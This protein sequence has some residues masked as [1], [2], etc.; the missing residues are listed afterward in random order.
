[1]PKSSSRQADFKRILLI[2]DGRVDLGALTIHR[3]GREIRMTPKAA[4]VLIELAR[5]PGVTLSRDE[6]LE[7]VWSNS[8]TTPDVV[9][10]A[11]TLLRRAFGDT[12]DASRVIETIPKVGYRLIV[13]ARFESPVPAATGPVDEPADEPGTDQLRGPG[14][15]RTESAGAAHQPT[16]EP[17]SSQRPTRRQTI[18]IA[19]LAVAI[20]SISF[21]GARAL[22]K[23]GN[24][25]PVTATNGEF[26]LLTHFPGAEVTP[27]LSSDGSRLTYSQSLADGVGLQIFV[28]SV[29]TGERR[30]LTDDPATDHS[31]ARWNSADSEL[32]Y[33]SRN[34]VR[35]CEIRVVD[36]ENGNQR[37]VAACPDTGGVHFDWDPLDEDRILV[38]T[39][40]PAVESPGGIKVLRR[41]GD[42]A[43]EPLVY[44]R[45]QADLDLEPRFSPD[46]EWIAF[47]RGPNPTS[48][49]YLMP[50]TGGEPRRIGDLRSRLDGFSWLPDSSGLVVASDHTGRSEVHLVDIQS[51]GS[52]PLGLANASQLEMARRAWRLTFQA[53]RWRSALSLVQLS[54]PGGRAES[55]PVPDSSGS[56]VAPAIAPDG[57]RAVFI[58]D[59]DGSQELWMRGR[60]G[61]QSQRLTN[62]RDRVLDRPVWSVD[63]ERIA[64]IARSNGVQ[65]LFE[66]TLETRGSAVLVEEAAALRDVVY[67]GNGRD[68][69]LVMWDDDRWQLVLCE[70]EAQRSCRLTPTG[71][72]ALRVDRGMDGTLWLYQ[73]D[74]RGEALVI[75]EA[76]LET[77]ERVGLPANEGWSLQGDRVVFHRSISDQRTLV[78]S[79]D[80]R[81]GQLA[82][83]AEIDGIRPVA[84]SRPQRFAGELTILLPAII[85]NTSD[86]GLLELQEP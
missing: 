24:P 44:V 55:A 35:G 12:P 67:A 32:L 36:V 15:V 81:T 63:G 40:E 43:Y 8:F 86:I 68:L 7:R 20:S 59:R 48:N 54:E 3:E 16:L 50:A 18:A 6:L 42:W 53:Q 49:L 79:M 60:D 69:W 56:D 66:H 80:W 76:S 9:G 2:A 37:S 13:D 26:R 34:A 10:H 72:A 23:P 31:Q 47:R 61:L 38:S 78:G 22:Y 74:A 84:Y 62:H 82:A 52:Q 21:L 58:S 27:A 85:E 29:A 5:Q 1:M 77:I 70:R 46:G 33:L 28:Q 41:N 57:D 19:L 4:G 73:P 71:L 64:Y 14:G 45:S 39:L 11:I 83:S 30:Q 65:E 17:D 25:L 51:G 75:D